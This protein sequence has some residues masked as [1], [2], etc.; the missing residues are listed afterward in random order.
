MNRLFD[1]VFLHF[2][3]IIV[4]IVRFELCGDVRFCIKDPAD[5]SSYIFVRF[6]N[7]IAIYL[8]FLLSIVFYVIWILIFARYV[9]FMLSYV[10]KENLNY[11]DLLTNLL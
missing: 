2:M 10:L 7:R 9:M 3:L 6:H 5:Y 8:M 1:M 11:V 4:L